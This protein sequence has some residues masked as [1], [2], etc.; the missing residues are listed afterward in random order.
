MLRILGGD[1]VGMSTVPEAI[2][3]NH[4]GMNIGGIS[5]I[6]NM[7]AGIEKGKLNHDDIKE[8]ALKSMEVFVKL[9]TKTV[10]HLN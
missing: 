8:Q 2:A 1:M 7:A 6:T 4:M 3:A 10:A 9:L 5:C